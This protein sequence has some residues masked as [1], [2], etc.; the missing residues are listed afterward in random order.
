MG[1]RVQQWFVLSG[2]DKCSLARLEHF[3]KFQKRKGKFFENRKKQLRHAVGKNTK[4]E[5][6]RGEEKRE[7]QEEIGSVPGSGDHDEDKK[8]DKNKEER[9]QKTKDKGKG[10]AK[11][12][13]KK[14]GIPDQTLGTE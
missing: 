12:E 5:K 2:V 6:G 10:K 3:A 13:D 14:G 9:P 1:V 4:R 7:E 11:Y 8:S